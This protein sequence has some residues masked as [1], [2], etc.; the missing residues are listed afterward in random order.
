MSLEDTPRPKK[1]KAYPFL[2]SRELAAMAACLAAF[3]ILSVLVDAP[4]EGPADP[5]GIPSDNVKAPWIFVGVQMT[6]KWMTAEIAGLILPAF[7]VLA[8]GAIPYLKLS[9]LAR[10]LIFSSVVLAIIFLTV[11]GF[12]S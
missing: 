9:F 8:L 2:V 3:F 12:F 11:W 7:A 5:S 6:L 1:V 10:T 4:L